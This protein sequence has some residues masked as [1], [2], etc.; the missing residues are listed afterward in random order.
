MAALENRVYGEMEEFIPAEFRDGF[1]PVLLALL[2][3]NPAHRSSVHE[4]PAIH[5]VSLVFIS[6]PAMLNRIGLSLEFLRLRP[7]THSP[8]RSSAQYSFPVF[9]S[10]YKNAIRPSPL[11]NTHFSHP[12]RF[13]FP[14]P[15]INST[16]L[17][18]F[19]SS[20]SSGFTH[21]VAGL[22]GSMARWETE[23]SRLEGSGS[24]DGGCGRSFPRNAAR[25]ILFVSGFQNWRCSLSPSPARK[26][27]FSST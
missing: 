9:K 18:A 14:D 6:V 11:L 15:V 2:R 13:S 7:V 19:L 22:G 23:A 12:V 21:S 10:V 5:L 16:G 4:L 24:G 27:A 20:L 8:G 26:K 25:Q 17:L 3:E 1:R